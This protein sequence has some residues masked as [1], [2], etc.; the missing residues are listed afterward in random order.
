MCGSC[1]FIQLDL[2]QDGLNFIPV[3]QKIDQMTE[4]DRSVLSYYVC[5]HLDFKT[6]K[7][8]IYTTRPAKCKK[9][10]CKGN[11]RAMK[12]SVEGTSA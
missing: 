5:E 12:V 8:G 11:P 7:C 2:V 1:C 9:F 3:A 4:E 6:K 10:F